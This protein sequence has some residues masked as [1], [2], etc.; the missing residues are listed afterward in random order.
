MAFRDKTLSV[1]SKTR[2]VARVYSNT[3]FH[4]ILEALPRG[5]VTRLSEQTQ[6]SRYDKSFK[7]YDH[8]V[9]L[10]YGQ[11][12][13]ARSLRELES[14]LNAHAA[15]HYH[16]GISSV[17]RS[18]LADANSRR[19]ATFFK[20]LVEQLMNQ[21]GRRQRQELRELVY[22]LD[23]TP[24]QLKGQGFDWTSISATHRTQGLKVHLMITQAS[25]RPVYLNITDTNIND[26]TD[27]RQMTLTPGAVY[28]MDKGYCDY[29]WWRQID[30]IGS[31]FVTR[32]KT[33]AGLDVV[34]QHTPEGKDILEDAHVMFRYASNRGHHRNT[35]HDKPLRR[36]K[37]AREG[38][39]PLVLATNDI[40]TPAAE[41]ALL[42]KQRWQ[43]E[44]FFKWLKQN[45]KLK[46]F[47]GRSRNAV[48]VQIYAAIIGYLLLWLYRKRVTTA[49]TTLHL[50]LVEIRATL[51]QRVETERQRDYRQRRRERHQIMAQKQGR[52]AL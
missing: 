41:I 11:F 16:L 21:A 12:S 3:R 26:I 25:Q 42:Y 5:L 6:A 31:R 34:A 23:S 17:R 8:L 45:L 50:L 49:D 44:L 46:R 39:A 35:Y 37:V 15:H 14:G 40:T 19:P 4:Q 18:T 7:P 48:M 2:G 13:G 38:K 47:L 52:L 22:L 9:A 27:A 1:D 51:F 43:V 20:E 32:F 10:L 24:I 36:I 29:N 33:N 28:V 30:E